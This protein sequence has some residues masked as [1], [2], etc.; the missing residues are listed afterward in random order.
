MAQRTTRRPLIGVTAG[1]RAMMSGAWAGHDAVV[2]PEHYVRAIRDAGA[3]P[4]I[5][6]P[7]DDWSERSSPSS[8]ASSSPAAPTSTPRHGA[9]TRSGPT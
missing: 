5:I 9:R 1:T 6:A 7:Q 2:V 4:V 8:T 3:R